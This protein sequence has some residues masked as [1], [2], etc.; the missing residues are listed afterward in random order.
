MALFEFAKDEPAI[1]PVSSTSFVG[2]GLSERFHLQAA[3]RDR[4]DVLGL[5]LHVVAE[6]FGGFK[7]VRR[8]I[9]LLCLDPDG[10]LVV[11]ELK[12]TEDGGHMELQ[13]L[14][15]AA[16]LRTMTSEQMVRAHADYRKTRGL[17]GGRE[18][19]ESELRAYLGL[20]EADSFPEP[21]DTPRIVLV[22]QEFSK[23]VTATVM[24]L[25]EFYDL[26]IRCVRLTMYRLNNRLLIDA[27]LIIPLPEAE[28]LMVEVKLK[29]AAVRAGGNMPNA[30]AKILGATIV[31][32]ANDKTLT[33]THVGRNRGLHG[34]EFAEDVQSGTWR[35]WAYQVCSATEPPNSN[36]F[37]VA[38]FLAKVSN[39]PS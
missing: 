5:N 28:E 3:L 20:T 27:G 36:W 4:I 2:E 17:D 12:R 33:Y 23:E 9:D 16:L 6:E 13:A 8:R 39:S 31:D 30:Q 22:S 21:N 29:D 37:S 25:N 38:E 32:R 10:N 7:D 24:W 1:T 15:Y 19:A 18:S 11:V 26:G 14:R 34:P 35:D